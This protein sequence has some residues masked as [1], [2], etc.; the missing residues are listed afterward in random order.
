MKPMIWIFLSTHGRFWMLNGPMMNIYLYPNLIS[1]NR[2][3]KKFKNGKKQNK[4]QQILYYEPVKQNE[5]MT[6]FSN[7]IAK[8]FRFIF[9]LERPFIAS[10]KGFS[11]RFSRHFALHE[12]DEGLFTT[13][14]P[15]LCS[16]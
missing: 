5:H 15:S 14:F 13:I 10:M 3:M 6:L 16:S 1:R 9:H 12:P 4:L 11:P 8:D 2:Q 7:Y